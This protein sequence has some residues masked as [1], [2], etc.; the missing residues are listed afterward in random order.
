[1]CQASAA[2]SATIAKTPLLFVRPR[3]RFRWERALT[4]GTRVLG[5]DK[6]NTGEVRRSRKTE[7]IWGGCVVRRER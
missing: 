6:S 2:E 7:D 5:S 1:V 3:E 4:S